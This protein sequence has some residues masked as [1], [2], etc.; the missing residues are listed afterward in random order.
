MA[1]GDGRVSEGPA[2]P[3]E[4]PASEL[5]EKVRNLPE[6]PGVYLFKDSRGKVIYIGK[7]ISLRNRVRSYFQVG[8]AYTRRL[9]GLTANIADL[10]YITTGSE[11]E[12]L[13]LESNLVKKYRPRYNIKLRDDKHFPYL[14]ITLD[15]DWPR[16]LIARSM[17]KDGS[18]YFGPYTRAGSLRETLDLLRRVFP[19][20]TCSNDAFRNARR[21]CLNYQI[22][23]CLGP[24]CGHVGKEAYGG[25]IRDMCSFLEG[26][27]RDVV[28]RLRSRMQGAA[29][30]L[31][32]EEAARL[33][34]QI[35]AVEDIAEKQNII[36]TDM[37]DRDVVGV[38]TAGNDAVAQ[39][40]QIRDGKMVGRETFALSDAAGAEPGEIAGSFLKLHYSSASS[41]PPEILLP[42]EPAD[43]E[44]IEEWL[45]G[46]RGARVRTRV[47][48]R[49]KPRELV[50]MAITNA[51]LAIE[52]MKP[53]E[54]R[55]AEEIR[56]ALEG[57]SSA[58]GLTESPHRIEGYDISNIQGR[59]PVGSMVV[60]RDG[61][62]D[63]SQYRKFR[64]KSRETP[65]DFAM[66]QE[67]L[68]RRFR[69][70][71]AERE[72][73]ADA[74]PRGEP[75]EGFAEF[76]DLILVDGGKGQLS[77]ALEVLKA[78]GLLHIPVIGL[79]KQEEEIFLPGRPDPVIL[80]RDSKALYLIQR[81]RDE[82]HRFAVGYH[83]KLRG[84]QGLRSLLDEIPGI[85]AKRKSALLRRF[86][87]VRGIARA[88]SEDISAVEGIGPV[89]AGKIKEA[90]SNLA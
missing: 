54:E 13:I 10:E 29:E 86:G 80:P 88:A 50:E 45:S 60:F 90:L 25:M 82:A 26:R 44:A 20:R 37:K 24:C 61:R 35:R 79:A 41:V 22:G 1:A 19:Y 47:P 42:A 28:S 73:R 2:I 72:E 68:F 46:L 52:E 64:I 30:R 39:V 15:E 63:K 23:R 65:D 8:Q 59:Q 66:M 78:L 11:V 77:A 70:G 21:P 48:S 3:A 55:E 62:P 40:F 17:K 7:A 32:F 75:P 33:R 36:F 5:I 38:A 67:V 71:L 89:L 34:D 31:D 6:L 83:R 76:P 18:R 57:L 43:F 16:A 85:G 14:R 27:T 74:S 49:G 58:V 53:E 9:T 12:A 4:A 84:R 87:S 51:R 81:L 56:S 69:R